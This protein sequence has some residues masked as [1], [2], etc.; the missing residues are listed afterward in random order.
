[1]DSK[2]DLEI[3]ALFQV[4]ACFIIIR[5]VDDWKISWLYSW[6]IILYDWI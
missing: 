6:Q 2:A 1:M 4:L 3:L 5:I